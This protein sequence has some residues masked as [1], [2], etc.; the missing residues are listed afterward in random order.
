MKNPVKRKPATPAGALQ[1]ALLAHLLKGALPAEAKGFG[2]TARTAAATFLAGLAQDWRTNAPVVAIEALPTSKSKATMRLGIV[3]ADSPFLVDS[4]ASELS[5]RGLGIARL[6]H[7]VLRASLS[8]EGAIKAI[9]AARGSRLTAIS[10]IYVEFEAH[11]DHAPD[12]LCL[13]IRDILAL[14]RGAVSDWHPMQAAMRVDAANIADEESASLLRWFGGGQ[15][16]ML[17]HCLFARDGKMLS[18][19]GIAT[20]E[21]DAFLSK[22]ARLRAFDWFARGNTAPLIIKSNMVSRVHRRVPIEL[23]IIPRPS[24]GKATQLSIHAGL[25]TSVALSTPPAETPLLRRRLVELQAKFGFDPTGHA[26]KALAHALTT[27]PHDAL[28][29]MDRRSLEALAQT[30]MSVTDRPRPVLT[31]TASPLDR[32]IVAFVW[33]PRD[34]MNTARRIAIG[35]KLQAVCNAPI[36]SWSTDLNDTGIALIRYTLDIRDGEQAP[37]QV[38]LNHWL[39]DLVRGWQA[40]VEAALLRVVG[41]DQAGH[42]ARR[43][44]PLLPQAYRDHDGA[45]EAAKD[46]ICLEKLNAACVHIARFKATES[47]SLHLKLYA[48]HSVDLSAAVPVLENFGFRVLNEVP[49]ALAHGSQGYIHD[50]ALSG[51]MPENAAAIE[52]AIAGVLD[53]GLENDRFNAL[54]VAA[55]LNVQPV[56]LFRALFR[57]LRQTG[58]NYGL[59][60]VVDALAKAP[61]IA[62]ALMALFAA[63]HD[64]MARRGATKSIQFANAAIDEGL[65]KITALDDD[66]VLRLY[67]SV[68][69]GCLRTNA[70]APQATEALAFKLDSATIPGLPAPKPWREIFVY[71]PRVE[72]IHLRAGP[73]ARGGLR[74]SDRRDDFRTEVLGLMK[75][76]RVKNAVIVPTGAKGGFYPKALPDPKN[77]DA[78]IAEGTE[79][80]R[81]FIRSLLSVTD[82]IIDG[83]IVHPDRVVIHDGDD[84]YFVVAADKGTAT[85]SDIANAIAIERGF[86]LGDAFASGGSVGYDHKAMG[87]TAKGGWISV[88]R[89]FAEMGVDV[90]SA[91]VRVAGCGD[92]SGDVFGN[93]MLLSKSI[94]L[95]AAFDHRH[96]FFDP[97]PDPAKSWVER[98]RLFALPRSSWADY[99]AKLVSKGGGIFPRDAKS[100]PLSPE[101]RA[102]LGVED[103]ALEPTAA[104]S[105][106]L[107]SAVDLLWFG[108]I[109]TYVKARTES[110]TDVGDRAN[111]ALRVAASEL[112]AKVIGEGANLG[113]TQA[114]R[115]EFALNGGRI[116]SDFI[117]N[118][119]GVDCSDIEVNIKIALGSEVLAGRLSQNARNTLLVRMTDDVAAIVLEDN[120]LQTLALSIAEREGAEGL[121][122]QI[123][124]IENLEAAGK[125]DRAVEGIAANDELARRGAEGKGLTRPEL[126]VVMATA[127]LLLQDAITG[128]VLDHDPA[129][130]GDLLRAFPAEMRKKYATAIAGHRLRGEI[131]ATKLAN[132]IINRMGL[133]HPFELADE[134]GCPLEDVAEAFVIAEQVYDIPALWAD[135]DAA[136]VAENTRLMLYDQVAIEMRAHMADILRN[137]VAGRTNAQAVL[138]YQPAIA[139]LT[140]MRT[141]L[142]PPEIKHQT[143]A[144]A[145]R[146][147]SAG[148][149]LEIADKLV[150]LA[151]LDGAIGIAAVSSQ[152]G[153]DVAITTRAFTALGEALGLDWAQGTAMQLDPSDPW[154]RLLSAGLARDFQTMRLVFLIQKGGKKPVENVAKWLKSNRSRVAS[155]RKMIDTARVTPPTPAMLAQIAGQARL[156]LSR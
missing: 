76:Q 106:I 137:A 67:R 51:T 79:S 54:M 30:A 87:I 122:A 65:A 31:L 26:G 29:A 52:V 130:L 45:E 68:I 75:A 14:V 156:L 55:K 83:K 101:I 148:A 33:L 121:P 38:A 104:I 155:F 124:L 77:R 139:R 43:F 28:I 109:G 138:D 91:P 132:R 88:T 84:P 21:G 89:H 99:N 108:G 42:L 90:Q 16:T 4:I 128:S 64:P 70:Y 143:D 10:F 133:I 36:L 145:L 37:D 126:A 112:R 19:L 98:A 96:I 6:L 40:A 142:L 74:W 39:A 118:S 95:V 78:W 44:A 136:I 147:T 144:F 27:L 46:I 129:T 153:T 62:Q 110:S 149:P 140:K 60:T 66:R 111:D 20:S 8:P 141:A 69:T 23:V 105:A 152:F 11:P 2:P 81:I 3:N 97:D 123:R 119:A 94:K 73:I 7:P 127:K 85:F 117:D 24:T 120:R 114:G 53:G 150:S 18:P 49:T 34:D 9:D 154:E 57:Y 93:G 80:Y 41:Q 1:S 115:I 107:K 100:I 12:A 86:W 146:L 50:F 102:L 92:M 82:N 56:V 32:H 113:V 71:S 72:G 58:M 13:A 131:V 17:G 35:E 47:G 63:R 22:A 5:A 15:F 151:Q 61:H 25:W 135:I 116:N 103:H 134:E 48:A 59:L 125:L